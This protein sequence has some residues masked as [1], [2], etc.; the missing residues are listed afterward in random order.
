[1]N[2]LD[3][4]IENGKRP[5][6]ATLF[7]GEKADRVVVALHGYMSNRRSDTIVNVAGVGAE[8]GVAVLSF[9]MP[10]HG[11]RIDQKETLTVK[12]AVSD[13]RRVIAYAK[14]NVSE[15]ISI[16]GTSLGAYFGLLAVKGN[17][18]IDHV[19]L[20]SPALNP[21]KILEN[22]TDS[23]AEWPEEREV[24][25]ATRILLANMTYDENYSKDEYDVY[26]CYK[27]RVCAPIDIIHGSDDRLV[28][29]EDVYSFVALNPSLIKVLTMPGEGHRFLSEEAQHKT[30]NW[31]RSVMNI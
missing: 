7:T 26:H 31:F 16:F 28:T 13:F 8:R 21:P 4:I 3:I 25:N 2:T 12:H 24:L 14:D 27:D 10:E 22:L 18:A 20:K 30:M 29:M 9:D 23:I 11:D 17:K 5:I 1:M 6:T 19:M 15:K